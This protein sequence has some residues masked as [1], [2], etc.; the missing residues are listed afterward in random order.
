M[1]SRVLLLTPARRFIANRSGLGYQIPL[2][3]V[4][5]GGPLLDAGHEVRLIDND[6]HGWDAERLIKEVRRFRPDYLLMGHTGS[7]A[8]HGTCIENARFLKAAFPELR[9][10]YGGVYPSYAA[11]STLRS[12]AAIDV[13]VRGEGEAI[14][15]D[16]L[17]AWAHGLSL[18]TVDGITWRDGETICAN[19]PRAAA[20]D[21]DAFRPGW[22]LVEWERYQLFGMGRSAGMQYSRGCPLTCTHCGQWG[23]WKRWRHRSPDNVVAELRTLAEKYGVKIVW[24]ADESF[25]ADQEVV[26]TLLEKLVQANLGLSLNVNMTAADVVRDADL[27]PLY[28]AA[29]VDYVIMGIE[30]LDDAIVQA[31]RK[32]N[33]VEISRAAIRALRQ[34]NIVAWA[35]IIYG[36]EDE[37]F[38]SMWEKFCN[39]SALDPDFLNAVYLTPHFWTAAGRATDPRDVIQTD[40]SKWTYR[41]QVIATPHLAPWQLFLGV[42]LTEMGVHLRPHSLK[43]LLWHGDATIRKLMRRSLVAGTF[44]VAAELWEFF[45]DTT[46]APRGTISELPGVPA[47][48]IRPSVSPGSPAP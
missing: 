41:N 23:F 5:L 46:F 26:I 27:L 4:L 37:T 17:H 43:R 11:E 34:N 18:A 47:R 25:A 1:A 33:P 21:L 42:K 15:V 35:N 31:V 20:Q 36:L 10:V 29:G 16:L 40:M 28:K 6:L 44:S 2:G 8:A 24:F 19:R 22:E 3:L 7:T 39:I 13:V 38:S 45:F 48:T 32:N 30:A 12:C 9:I 14:V